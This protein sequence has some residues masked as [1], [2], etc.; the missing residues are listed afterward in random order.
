VVVLPAL[1]LLTGCG[2]G[3]RQGEGFPA[4]QSPFQKIGENWTILCMEVRGMDRRQRAESIAEALRHTPGLN[5]NQV[6]VVH[7]SERSRIY[8]GRYWRAGD[9]NTG[10]F[11]MPRELIMDRLLI[12][13][14]TFNG[15]RYFL[16][17]RIMPEPTPDVGNPNWRL[18]RNPG[19]YTLRIALF[20]S[21]PGFT[22]RREAAAA[23]CE[24]LRN[25][26]HEAYYRH[27]D[28]T[29][30][31]FV[32]SFGEDALYEARKSGV[33]VS[34]PSPEVQALQEKETFRFE[35]WNLKTLASQEGRQRSVRA[36]RVL[37]VRDEPDYEEF[38]E[39]EGF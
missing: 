25:K 28:F 22:K 35:L 16:E 17:S 29:S 34:L 37:P 2:G 23:Y 7:D 39:F 8:Y 27:G 18:D 38:D 24:E 12:K 19:V 33:L 10:K 6:S 20:F 31:V 1:A 15:D 14:L 32:G 26:G 5:G 4:F 36:S 3:A 9:K 30:E 21:E 11:A 13:D